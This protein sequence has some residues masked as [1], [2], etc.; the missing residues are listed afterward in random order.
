MGSGLRV[1]VRDTAVDGLGEVRVRVRVR[2]MRLRL[3]LGRGLR[4]RV[5][6]MGVA[7]LGEGV[8]GGARLIELESNLPGEDYGT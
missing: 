3:E 8:T 4:V 1:R 2:A 7:G 6:N 5:R